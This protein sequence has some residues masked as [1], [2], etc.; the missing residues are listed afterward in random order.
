MV[1]YSMTQM[2]KNNRCTHT[3]YATNVLFGSNIGI[4]LF[5][6]LFKTSFLMYFIKHTASIIVHLKQ[7]QVVETTFIAC[8]HVFTNRT[9]NKSTTI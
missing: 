2:E 7:E 1:F 5:V 3:H 8:S 6:S 9:I 4:R